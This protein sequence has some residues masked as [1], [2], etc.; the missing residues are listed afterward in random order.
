VLGA[1]FGVNMVA[2]FNIQL[3]EVAFALP[4]TEGTLKFVTFPYIQL[5]V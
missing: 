1:L 4:A 2:N 5:I 3:S